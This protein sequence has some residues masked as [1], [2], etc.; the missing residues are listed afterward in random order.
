MGGAGVVKIRTWV[1]LD[2]HAHRC[3]V[4]LVD[5]ETGELRRRRL[6][7][8]PTSVLDVLIALPGPVRAVYEA[9]PTGFALA[10]AGAERGVDV[11][12][13]APG[14]TP[15]KPGD[16]VKTDAK[17]AERLARLLLAGEL[18]FVRVPS[19]EEERLRD[20]VRAR[21][22]LRQD[23]MR[24]RHRLSKFCLRRELRF[25]GPGGAWTRGHLRWLDGLRL[26]DAAS[27]V[28]HADYLAAVQ[29]LLQRRGVLEDALTREA[30]EGT[31]AEPVARLRAFRGLDTLSA[32]GLVAEVGEF[33]RFAR[34]TQVGD[35]LGLVPSEHTSDA[36]RRQGA[37]TTAGPSHAR[38]LLVE[39][40][41]HYRHRPAIGEAL[42][43]RQRGVDPRVCQVAWRA[44][45]RLYARWQ[46]LGQERGKP[47][48][49]VAVACARE[50]SCFLWEAA[51]LG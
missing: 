33:A 50:L 44:Q 14:L 40:A 42:E 18:G 1:G 31:V 7:G 41:W 23:L 5:A 4:A 15:R 34:P 6:E 8:P 37:I 16:R 24:A 19:V 3:H 35:Y 10:R 36:K 38:R 32:I 9:G 46:V 48:G 29:G 45:R 13:C 12:V 49:T 51:T 21:E 47:G 25:P 17:D 2:V 39:A 27:R 43:R 28:V 11:R 20:L 22:D 30:L 26:P